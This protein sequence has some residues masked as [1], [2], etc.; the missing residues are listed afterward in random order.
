MDRLKQAIY[1]FKVNYRYLWKHEVCRIFWYTYHSFT[2][3]MS[4]LWD[5]TKILFTMAV[6]PLLALLWLP[7]IWNTIAIKNNNKGK[8]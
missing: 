8:Q 6:L 1:N 5:L 2:E 4:D 7:F 3:L